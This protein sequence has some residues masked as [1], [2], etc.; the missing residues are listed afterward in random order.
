MLIP[1]LKA[2]SARL[3]I[4][5]NPVRYAR[6]IGVR[7]GD[8]CRLLDLQPGT[9][10]SEPYLV[11]LGHHVTVTSGVQFVTHDGGVW[12]FRKD[13]PDIDVIAPIRIGN[14]VFIGTRAVILPGVVIGDNCV[15]AA[16]AVVT[17]DVPS[18]TVVGGVPARVIKSTEKYWD[19]LRDRAVFIR[20]LNPLAKKQ[21]LLAMLS[22]T[23]ASVTSSVGP[24]S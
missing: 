6:S 8:D 5:R 16:G 20:S 12:I 2:L 22:D 11:S 18:N 4:R 21:H 19:G 3:A 17:R 15:V 14:N 24:T 7:I 13:H 23:S 1:I 9:F 10:G